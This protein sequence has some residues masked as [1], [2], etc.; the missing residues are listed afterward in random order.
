[1]TLTSRS[2]HYKDS[3][4]EHCLHSVSWI[5]RWNFTKLTQILHWDRGRKWLDFSDLDLIFKVTLALCWG[6]YQISIAYW[7]F[8]H[9]NYFVEFDDSKLRTSSHVFLCLQ[10]CRG[11]YSFRLSVCSFLCSFIHSFVHTSVLFVEL[12]ESFTVKQL[13]W[14][15]SHQQLFR[16]HSYL[17]HRYPGGLAIIP[18]LL[19]PGS[20]P[21]GGARGQNLGHL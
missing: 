3:K 4:N 12:L 21:R 9:F 2:L 19:T 15:I 1:M 20:M 6:G 11:I 10:L 14:S 18:L 5:N 8:F 17:D 16:K 7:H 13:K